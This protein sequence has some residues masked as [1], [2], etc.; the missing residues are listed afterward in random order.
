MTILEIIDRHAIHHPHAVAILNDAAEQDERQLT[1]AELVRM[2]NQLAYAIKSRLGDDQTPIV[3]YGHKSIYMVVCFLACVKSGRAYCPIDVSS[4]TERVATI[5]NEVKPKLILATEPLAIAHPHLLDKQA[6]KHIIANGKHEI[7]PGSYVQPGDVFYI[8]FTSGST[9]TPK[10]VQITTSCL[11][12][13]LKWA[14][15]IGDMDGFNRPLTF[16]NQSPFSFDGSVIDI[17]VTLY[18]GATVWILEKAVQEN[19]GAL[20]KSFAR[21]HSVVWNSTPSFADLCLA[22]QS[23]SCELLPHLKLFIFGG[24]ILHHATVLKLQSRF[25]DASIVNAYGPT[26]STDVIT[27]VVITP[28]LITRYASLP[29]GKVKEGSFVVIIDAHG[30]ELSDKE[31]GEIVIVGD[32]VSIGYWN[33][34]ELNDKYFKPY[35]KDGQRLRSYH[36]GDRGYME[37]GLLFYC[38]R[39]DYQ[40]KLHGYRMELEDIEYHIRQLDEVSNVVVVPQYQ[41]DKVSFLKAYVMRDDPYADKSLKAVVE[42]KKRLRHLLPEYMIPKIIEF[43]GALPMNQN[44]KIDRKKLMTQHL[45]H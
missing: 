14:S 39:M 26:E 10:G 22:D 31:V 2:S 40:I 30:D 18:L 6:I 5:I 15:K 35:L 9:G 16:M 29:V 4:P 32:T 45:S 24:E 37:D 23:F 28:E 44:G 20:M 42:F 3:V 19:M 12:H 17:Y 8:I 43:V 21:S 36:T 13:F 27:K 25:P 33:R 34:P 38:G 11:D 41:G 1:Y 7:D